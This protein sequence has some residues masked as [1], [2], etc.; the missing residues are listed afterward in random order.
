MAQ[1]VR[2]ADYRRGAFPVTFERAE[3]TLL[4][5]L[6]SRRVA[7]GEWRDYAIAHG[8]GRAVF[9]VFRR[10]NERPLHT[11]VKRVGADGREGWEVTGVPGRPFRADSLRQA[12][13]VFD[14]GLRL[15]PG[16]QG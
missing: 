12:L 13:T 5:A 14:R 4:M 1:L 16:G 3:M 8:P 7:A 10:A 11:V 9:A 15:L 6:Y 2:I